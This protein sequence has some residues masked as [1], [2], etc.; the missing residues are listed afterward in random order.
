MSSESTRVVQAAEYEK[1]VGGTFAFLR[2]KSWH[3]SSVVFVATIGYLYLVIHPSLWPG[4]LLISLAH[5]YAFVNTPP[6]LE[7]LRRS[8]GTNLR[9]PVFRSLP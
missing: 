5:L 3:P 6:W 4:M 2:D 7:S 8:S 1:Y 9:L